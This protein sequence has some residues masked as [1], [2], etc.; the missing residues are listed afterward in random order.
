MIFFGL[1][2]VFIYM[3]VTLFYAFKFKGFK[4]YDLD[5]IEPQTHFS[6]LIPFRNEAENLPRLLKCLSELNYPQHLFQ[7]FLVDDHSEDDSHNICLKYVEKLGL[8]NVRVLENQNLATSPK[9]SAILTALEHINTGYVV[10]TDADCLLPENWLL[11]FDNCIQQTKADLIAGPVR[12]IEEN[13]FWQKFQVLDLMSLQVIGLGSFNAKTPLMC[14][15]ANLAYNAKTLKSLNAFEK[16][17]QHISGDDIFT[18][19]AIH[20]AGKIVKAVVHLEATIWTKAQQDFKEL[21]QQRI[22]WASK[23]KHY[24]S[25]KLIGLGILVFLTNLILVLSLGLAFVFEGFK[26]WFWLL[27]VLKITTDFVVLYV[28][29]Q[30]FKTGMCSKD[31]LLM[32]LIYPFA[33]VYFALLS[34]GGKFNWKGRAYKV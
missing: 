23:A 33:N 9:K 20:K 21:T 3:T 19:E 29:K 5:S 32:L 26:F 27:W 12:M 16:H 15:A 6:I 28:G 13:S 14:N 24:Q 2:V 31:Y 25:Q 11:Y 10:T 4:P 18:L 7:I 34:F 1:L 17:Q 30:F 22:R 8:K